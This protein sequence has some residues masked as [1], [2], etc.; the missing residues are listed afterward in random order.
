MTGSGSW[1]PPTVGALGCCWECSRSVPSHSSPATTACSGPGP[2]ERHYVS[3]L[4]LCPHRP[5]P[6]QQGFLPSCHPLPF[7]FLSR[8][9]IP[10][11]AYLDHQRQAAYESHQP[12]PPFL[13]SSQ[14]LT[15]NTSSWATVSS[16]GFLASNSYRTCIFRAGLTGLGPEG[17]WLG[18]PG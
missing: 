13:G 18:S 14:C 2:A 17:A 9:P 7:F 6:P 12:P 11:A 1:R 4:S 5:S 8:P 16:C 15:S 3:H 10:A